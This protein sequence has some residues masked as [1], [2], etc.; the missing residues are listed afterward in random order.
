[1]KRILYISLVACFVLSMSQTGVALKYAWWLLITYEPETKHVESIPVADIDSSWTLAEP[2]SKEAIPPE[3]MN[4][5]EKYYEPDG[6][7][8][9]KEGDFNA[10]GKRDRAVVGIYKDKS[11]G[12]GRF[13]LILTE[14][15][16]NKWVKSFVF[17]NP[18]KAGFGI[19]REEKGRLAWYLCMDCDILS[20][21]KWENGK[22]VLVPFEHR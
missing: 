9:S 22:Y 4:D 13:L 14:A 12:V 20:F 6:Y 15:Q 1:M 16:K 21:V 19:L 3:E 11:G 8:F 18:G 5:F 17:K 10:D 2:L 7:S